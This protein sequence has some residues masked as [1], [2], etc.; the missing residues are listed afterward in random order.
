MIKGREAL[1]SIENDNWSRVEARTKLRGVVVYI[2]EKLEIDE[3]RRYPTGSYTDL[4]TEYVVHS[5]I[6]PDKSD[7]DEKYECTE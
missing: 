4:P 2:T 7:I 1:D 5:I 6:T 3:K